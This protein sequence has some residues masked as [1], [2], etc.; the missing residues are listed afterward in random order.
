MPP[1]PYRL[2]HP[3]ARLTDVDKETL[4]AWTAAAMGRWRGEHRRR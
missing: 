2:M 4:C 3:K 1:W